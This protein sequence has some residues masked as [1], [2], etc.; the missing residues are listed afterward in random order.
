MSD[1][2]DDY[3]A[4]KQFRQAEAATGK[5]T[6]TALAAQY[7]CTQGNVSRIVNRTAWRHI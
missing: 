4:L 5:H 3:R 7:G 1:T 6:H 2:I